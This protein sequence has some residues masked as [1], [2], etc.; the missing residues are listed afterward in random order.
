MSEIYLGIDLSL[1][2][3]GWAL[4]SVKDR[5]PT[6]E[7]FGLLRTKADLSDGE[8]LHQ[9]FDGIQEILDEYP[10]LN[11]SIAREA[12]IVKFP[13]PTMQVLKAHGVF[14]YSLVDYTVED[15]PLSTV[16]KWARIITK[17]PGKRNDK[18]MVAE[19]IEIYYG[20]KFDFYTSR[21]KLIDDISDAI[22]VITVWLIQNKRIGGR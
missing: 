22:A 4:V 1:T 15:V 13:K 14:E 5:V 6:V 9:I 7:D 10:R 16:K 12:P 19:A 17:S 8:R 18:D 21:G 20:K 3:T 2:K 11:E